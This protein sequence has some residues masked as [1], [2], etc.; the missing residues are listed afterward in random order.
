MVAS[1][2]NIVRTKKGRAN[3]ALGFSENLKVR[4]CLCRPDGSQEPAHLGSQ[5]LGLARQLGGGC[6]DL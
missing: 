4:Q 2:T 5:M 3:A 6:E 1:R